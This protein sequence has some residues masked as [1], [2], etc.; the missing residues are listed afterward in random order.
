VAVVLDVATTASTATGT[1]STGIGPSSTVTGA[2]SEPRLTGEVE[3]ILAAHVSRADI[4]SRS[5]ER[6]PSTPVERITKESALSVS[7]QN[8]QGARIASVPPPSPQEIARELLPSYGWD[9]GQFSCLDAMWIRESDW[10][11]H[12]TNATSGAYGIPQALPPEKMS[13]YGTDWAT[14]PETQ[15]RWGLWYIRQ[16]YGSP[17]G[18]W[19]FWESHGWY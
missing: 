9:A 2:T 6:L 8:L 11:P 5:T 1:A 19:Y 4:P 17:C 13:T 18:A 14:N 10:N 12:A 3:A 7:E 16:S 15:I